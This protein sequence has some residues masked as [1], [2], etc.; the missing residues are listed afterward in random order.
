M[1]SPNSLE[2]QKQKRELPLIYTSGFSEEKDQLTSLYQRRRGTHSDPLYVDTKDEGLEHRVVH[3]G[4]HR[5][6]SLTPTEREVDLWL[7]F[8]NT[9]GRQGICDIAGRP[10]EGDQLLCLECVRRFGK[11]RMTTQS[12]PTGTSLQDNLAQLRIS[13]PTSL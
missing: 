4:R 3:T 12:P 10:H 6:S 8:I 2:F 5:V 1:I 13:A 7:H 9:V 11:R